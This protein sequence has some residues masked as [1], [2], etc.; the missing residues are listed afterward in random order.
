MKTILRYIVFLLFLLGC[1]SDEKKFLLQHPEIEFVRKSC[2]EGN[3]VNCHAVGSFALKNEEYKI[4]RR[5]FGLSCKEKNRFS[6]Y[7]LGMI[8]KNIDKNETSQ[9][10]YFHKSCI[11]HHGEGCRELSVLYGRLGNKEKELEYKKKEC[12]LV[13][14]LNCGILSPT[15]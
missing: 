12:I 7:E 6:C 11:Y 15:F 10:N 14:T 1:N 2:R 3:I 4:A 8:A 13:G 9:I 5:Y